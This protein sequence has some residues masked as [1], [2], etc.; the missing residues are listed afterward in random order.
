MI[1]HFTVILLLSWFAARPVLLTCFDPISLLSGYPINLADI[2]Y[3]ARAQHGS[4]KSDDAHS[5]TR[6]HRT[7]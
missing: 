4:W 5:S 2:E 1:G 7:R 6:R 3:G